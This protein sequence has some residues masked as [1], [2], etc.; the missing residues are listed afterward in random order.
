VQQWQNWALADMAPT[1]ET[2]QFASEQA[3]NLLRHLAFQI[4]RTGKLCNA[5]AV[6]DVRVAIRRFVQTIAV[7][8]PYFPGKDIRKVRR[9][10]KKIMVAAGEVRNCDVA[11]K[12]IAKSRLP[13]VDKVQ[14]KL[15]SRRKESSRILVSEL[16]RW[17]DR[18]MSLKWRAALEAALARN[19]DAFGEAAIQEV[20][21]RTLRQMAKNFQV[22]GNEAA[23]SKASPGDL[24]RFRIL[25][26][27]FRYTLEL[28]GALY[29]SSLNRGIARI[30]RAQTLLGDINDC[31]TVANIVAQY[32]GGSRLAG[33]LRKRQR[34]K[35][36][37]FRQFWREEFRDGEQQRNW[38][39]HSARPA[40]RSRGIKKPMASSAT[41]RRKS[42]AVA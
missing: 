27:K 24:H 9:R 39:D 13:D 17:T 8:E 41:L 38:I 5:D 26:K 21:R 37:E 2:R 33:R 36:D 40:E 30:K 19:Q 16:K 6:H 32:N 3:G 34:N 25:A 22:H 4:N 35:T 23:S 12:F 20:S 28:F 15:H 29:G 31:V 18:Q 42:V 14:S 7:F 10:L 11:L 1:T